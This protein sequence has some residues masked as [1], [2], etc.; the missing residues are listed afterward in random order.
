MGI[1]GLRL[2]GETESAESLKFRPN[3][4][5][6]HYPPEVPHWGLDPAISSGGEF[7]PPSG[8][9][10]NLILLGSIFYLSLEIIII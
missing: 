9:L 2:Q 1:R 5:G 4:N 7:P 3:G 6:T 8:L 10:N